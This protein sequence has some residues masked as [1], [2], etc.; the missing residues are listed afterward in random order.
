MAPVWLQTIVKKYER[1]LHLDFI[2][3]LN[4]L[5]KIGEEK[6]CVGVAT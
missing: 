1:K 2:I 5:I 6:M 4:G 3:F